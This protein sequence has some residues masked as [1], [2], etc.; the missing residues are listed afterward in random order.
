MGRNNTVFMVGYL[1]NFRILP[2]RLTHLILYAYTCIPCSFGQL[3]IRVH[4]TIHMAPRVM[5]FS[6]FIAEVFTF[7]G[8]QVVDW[9][10]L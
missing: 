10:D 7:H 5:H 8:E 1:P 3:R 6:A 2:R 9:A 4:I